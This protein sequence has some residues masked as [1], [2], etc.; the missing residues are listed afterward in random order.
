MLK[1][2]NY[3]VKIDKSG[4]EYAL[5]TNIKTGK[6][7]RVK[8]KYAKKRISDLT[9]KEKRATIETMLKESGTGDDYKQ[10]K[11]VIEKMSKKGFGGIY[12]E[13]I[14]QSNLIRKEITYKRKKDGQRPLTKGEMHGRVKKI[15]IEYR[16]G[17]ATRFRYAWF[18]R[19]VLDRYYDKELKKTIVECDTGTFEADSLT[20]SGDEFNNMVELCQEEYDDIKQLDLCS[21]DG[22]ACVLYY[23]RSDK[24]IIKQFELGKGCGFSFDFDQRD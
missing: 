19:P 18:Y 1:R 9:Y 2:I 15:A 5:K 23:N 22:G 10:Y 6:S 7:T 14:E 21:L 4:R 17:K 13:Y 16:T 11:K 12:S 3:T 20:R 24:S 8:V